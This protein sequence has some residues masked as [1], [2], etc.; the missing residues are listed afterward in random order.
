MSKG[1]FI[2]GT[3]TD[4]GKTTAAAALMH[5]LIHSG[6]SVT[7]FKPVAAGCDR[8]PAGLRNQDALKLSAL[9]SVNV[10]YNL[11]NPYAYEAPIAPHIAALNTQQPIDIDVIKQC[12]ESIQPLADYTIVEGAGGWLV[13]INQHQTMADVVKALRIP[14]L[15]VVGLKLGCINHALLT[16]AAIKQHGCQVTGWI[17]NT[18]DHNMDN[19][20]DNLAFLKHRLPVPLLATIPHLQSIDCVIDVDFDLQPLR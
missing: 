15:L 20:D 12:Y 1:F 3:D 17:A 8:T 18:L 2:T 10:D 19:L 13:P 9:S 6:N 5:Y 4:I 14:V 11:V 7:A 16:F